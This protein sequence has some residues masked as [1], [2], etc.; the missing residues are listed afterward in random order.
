VPVLAIMVMRMIAGVIILV[1]VIRVVMVMPMSVPVGVRLAMPMVVACVPMHVIMPVYVLAAPM[2]MP[3]VR[4]R[5]IMPVI[6]IAMSVPTLRPRSPPP[7]KHQPMRLLLRSTHK[8]RSLILLMMM[9]PEN[10]P[11]IPIEPRLLHQGPDLRL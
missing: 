4:V 8:H 3:I 5:M 6:V 11:Q 10:S 1:R 7:R 9:L 2:I